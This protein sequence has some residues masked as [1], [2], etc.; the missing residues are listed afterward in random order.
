MQ[1]VQDERWA[2][3]EKQQKA[4]LAKETLEAAGISA[5]DLIEK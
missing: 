3:V 5:E 2:E 1:A 4:Q